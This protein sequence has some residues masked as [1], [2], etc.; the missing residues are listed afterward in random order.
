MKNQKSPAI[1]A[2]RRPSQARSTRLVGDILE[3]AI[4]VLTSDGA[5]HFTTARVAERAGVSVGSLYQYFPNKEAILF[6]LQ[7]DEWQETRQLLERI[8]ADSVRSPFERL[9]RAVQAFFLTEW[10]EAEFRMA[11]DDATPLYRDTP[12]AH[13]LWKAYTRCMFVFMDEALP[14]APLEDRVF[15]ADV[16]ATVMSAV[17]ERIS[18]QARS[19]SEVNAMAMAI[20]EMFC[21]YLEGISQRR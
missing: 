9:R 13:E 18:E 10:R 19:E 4:R 12:E 1:S 11:L 5:R 2:R 16:I 21:A 6:R 17:G 14:Q 8:L 7:A 20:G 3:A 15:A